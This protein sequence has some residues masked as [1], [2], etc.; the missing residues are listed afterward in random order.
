MTKEEFMAML[1]QKINKY[2]EYTLAHWDET[3]QVNFATMPE[4]ER[5]SLLRA[6]LK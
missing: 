6:V 3:H 5:K 2:C 4:K 1:P